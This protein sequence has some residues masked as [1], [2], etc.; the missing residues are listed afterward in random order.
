MINWKSA[1]KFTPYFK[2]Y[3]WYE[4]RLIRLVNNSFRLTALVLMLS[5]LNFRL[6]LVSAI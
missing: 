1:A 6:F 3:F 4:L 2:K 5:W